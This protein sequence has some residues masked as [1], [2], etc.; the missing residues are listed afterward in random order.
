MEGFQ[1]YQLPLTITFVDFKKAF[2]SI[3]RKV[4]FAVL[5]HSGIPEDV[6]NAISALYNNSK[7]A[8]MFDGNMSDPCDIT[9]GVLQGDVF[10]PFLFIIL[11]D[12]LMKKATT[13]VNS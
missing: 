12:H 6:V 8:V 9:N 1:D 2:D 4:M 13:D 3:E 11:V 5:R 10:P 7:G